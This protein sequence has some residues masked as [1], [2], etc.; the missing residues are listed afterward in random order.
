MFPNKWTSNFTN[1][2]STLTHTHLS[3]TIKLACT[4]VIQRLHKLYS[5]YT[6][7]T[8]FT[9]VIQHHLNRQPRHFDYE[10]IELD[11]SFVRLWFYI[12]LV[13]HTRTNHQIALDHRQRP[14]NKSALFIFYNH[15]CQHTNTCK[16][17]RTHKSHLHSHHTHSDSSPNLCITNTTDCYTVTSVSLTLLLLCNLC[18]T[19]TTDCYKCMLRGV[20]NIHQHY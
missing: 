8:A 6:C 1:R 9:H 18:I 7:S 17:S 20:Q 5:I 10:T 4:H 13:T 15:G 11:Y 14:T 2:M 12:I 19:D 16:L 3:K